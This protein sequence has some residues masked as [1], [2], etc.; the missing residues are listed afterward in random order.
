MSTTETI[1]AQEPVARFTPEPLTVSDAA[2]DPLSVIFHFQNALQ[3]RLGT[4]AKVDSS[5]AMRQQFINQMA[6]AMQEE[7]IEIIRET[8]YKNPDFVPFGWKK[9][10][11]GDPEK[12]KEELVDQLHFFVNLCIVAGMGPQELCARYLA[13]NKINHTRQDNGY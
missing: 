5:P 10:Q 4:W 3:E 2:S 7:T 13:K 12:F 11:L 9:T 8:A 6:I 1:K